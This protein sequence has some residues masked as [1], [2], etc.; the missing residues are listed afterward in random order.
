MLYTR[1]GM[2]FS[3]TYTS[4]LKLL[5][6]TSFSG[7]HFSMRAFSCSKYDV[8]YCG[9]KIN[10]AFVNELVMLKARV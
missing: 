8:E 2:K 5:E 4:G 6:L 3:K 9:T 7:G 10:S 1:N